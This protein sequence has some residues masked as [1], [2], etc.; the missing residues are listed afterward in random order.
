MGLEILGLPNFARP[1]LPPN[2]MA[3]YLSV[4]GFEMT[5][6]EM[7]ASAVF[8]LK[9][10]NRILDECESSRFVAENGCDARQDISNCP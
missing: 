5:D 4:E 1:N 7:L 3:V 2:E 6:V 8:A 9:E 10:T